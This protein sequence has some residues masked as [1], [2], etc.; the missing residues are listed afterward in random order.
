VKFYLGEFDAKH[1]PYRIN[2]TERKRMNETTGN[3]WDYQNGENYIAIPTNGVVK[4]NGEN[5]MGRGLALQAKRRHPDVPE[6]LG[7]M[8]TNYGGNIPHLVGNGLVSFPVKHHWRDPADLALIE[9]SARR[10]SEIF[11]PVTK[12]YLPRVGCGNGWLKWVDVKLI[13][14]KHLDDRFT[15]VH[16]TSS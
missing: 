9:E 16:P 11:T 6:Y 1:Y 7:D 14:E 3:I 8:I 2:P 15:V 5:V 12:I 13:L 4:S 10:I